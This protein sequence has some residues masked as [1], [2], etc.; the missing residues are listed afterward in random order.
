MKRFLLQTGLFFALLFLII[1]VGVFTPA[2]PRASG[3]LLFGQR[4]KDSL[5]VHTPSPRYIFVAGSNISFGLDSRMLEDSLGTNVV[6]TGIQGSIGLHYMM[7]HVLDYTRPGDTVILAPEYDQ[8]FGNFVH[9]DE[10]LY[11]TVLDVDMASVKHLTRSQKWNLLCY[12][13]KYAFSKFK[14]NEY[15]GYA[16]P[17]IYGAKSFNKYGDTY[18][19][20]TMEPISLS[21]SKGFF[22]TYNPSVVDSIAHFALQLKSRGAELMITFCAYDKGSWTNNRIEISMV[23]S[24]LRTIGVPVLGN[25]E[26]YVFADSMIF[27]AAYHLN[28]NGVELRTQRLI[29]DLKVKG[30]CK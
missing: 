22:A 14:P 28:R 5:L 26:R 12:T 16:D 30:N 24:A 21:A 10:P 20:W 3:S 25:P 9:G 29:E 2:T 17:G 1:A 23:D 11:R 7:R 4:I 6:N 19:H 15:I 18:L 13:P 8:F 27:E